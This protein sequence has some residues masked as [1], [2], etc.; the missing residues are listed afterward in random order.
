MRFKGH[1]PPQLVC[2]SEPE[3]LHG[4]DVS[5]PANQPALVGL[6]DCGWWG[7]RTWLES[8]MSLYVVCSV[9]SSAFCPKGCNC[10]TPCPHGVVRGLCAAVSRD[11]H[12]SGGAHVQSQDTSVAGGGRGSTT[13]Q[14]ALCA[15][16]RVTTFLSF[17]EWQQ[18]ELP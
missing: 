9:L 7:R 5:L 4:S 18:G 2:G 3:C 10:V 1:F 12:E 14:T 6:G 15:F 11:S 8:E 17:L 13:V 16:Q